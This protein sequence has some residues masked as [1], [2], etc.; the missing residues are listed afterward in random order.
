[1]TPLTLVFLGE[2]VYGSYFRREITIGLTL[3]VC[4][5]GIL[6]LLGNSPLLVL[7]ICSM[8]SLLGAI[9]VTRL[10][11]RGP[12]TREPVRISEVVS[13][14][15]IFVS[16]AIAMSVVSFLELLLPA[17]L[18]QLGKN[19]SSSGVLLSVM[20]VA[21]SVG[22]MFYG[23]V[24]MPDS[25]AVQSWVATSVMIAAVVVYLCCSKEF[26]LARPSAVSTSR[27]GIRC[28]LFP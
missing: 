8:F 26:V 22:A 28:T 27:D 15:P 9:A 3:T 23:A 4:A 12:K 14:W 20:A 24:K 6:A 17:F 1:M 10:P 2:R 11:E 5:Y 25:Y 16:A 7:S 18:T 19:P 13:A 21:S